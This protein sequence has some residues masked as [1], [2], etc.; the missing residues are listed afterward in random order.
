MESLTLEPRLK[1]PQVELQFL[2]LS[3]W[4]CFPDP[5]SCCLESKLLLGKQIK[6][7]QFKECVVLT[8]ICSQPQVVI[9]GNAVMSF[10]GWLNFSALEFATLMPTPTKLWLQC[11]RLTTY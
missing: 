10:P 7:W 4:F 8:W 9:Q 3:R 2:A 6:C 1:W 5:R 11:G